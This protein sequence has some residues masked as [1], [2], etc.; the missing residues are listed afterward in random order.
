VI[1]ESDVTVEG[2]RTLHI[3]DTR[4]GMDGDRPAGSGGERLVVFWLH[5]TPN[6]GTPPEPLFP[7]AERRGI[8]FVSYDRPGYG[9]STARPDRDVASAAADVASAAD[10]LGIDRFAVM[11]HSGGGPHA[12]AC[13]ALLRDRVASVVS[14]SGLAPFAADGLDYF[15]GMAPSG[16][17]ELRAAASGRS[18]LEDLLASSPFDPEI[19]TA[20]D[21]A[22]LAGPWSWLA[23]V[24]M[25]ALEA[26]FAA[27]VD[28]DLAYVSP[29]GFDPEA[30]RVPVLLL[31]GSEDRIVPSAHGEWLGRRCAASDL[32]IREGDG[33]ISV[34]DA[35]E[36]ALDWLVEHAAT[37]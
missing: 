37:A 14:V 22:A 26:G 30:V 18:T 15:A 1:E 21:R 9:G 13:G 31:H 5:G 20:S 16:A 29:W 4:A 11:G 6:T 8:R 28:D 23:G 34:L 7:A 19:F 2:G 32:L 33:H 27:M 17:A 35:A 10:A 3:Y 25:Q 24:A 12:L 36:T